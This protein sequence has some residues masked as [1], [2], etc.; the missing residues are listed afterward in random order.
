VGL[1]GILVRQR[2]I[3]AR[4][5]CRLRGGGRCCG[6]VGLLRAGV[7]GSANSVVGVVISSKWRDPLLCR[8]PRRAGGWVAGCE[9]VGAG[10]LVN[11]SHSAARSAAPAWPATGPHGVEVSAPLGRKFWPP[12][13]GPVTAGA[14]VTGKLG[15]IKRADGSVQATR[16]WDYLCNGRSLPPG[17]KQGCSVVLCRLS[18][19]PIG[20]PAR[21]CR[22]VVAVAQ[23][24]A[25]AGRASGG[26][27][28][29]ECHR[30]NELLS[31]GSSDEALIAGIAAGSVTAG[32]DFV[33]RH[34]SRVFGLALALVGDP[35]TAE[36]VAQDTFLRVWRHAGRF[37]AGKGSVPTWLS[38]ISR[39]L[40]IDRLRAQRTSPVDPL[41]LRA[42]PVAMDSDPIDHV[43]R[44]ED[45]EQVRT[46]VRGLP[47]PQQRAVVL[48]AFGQTAAEISRIE[49]IPLG[50][51]KTRI[52]SAIVKLRAA[53]SG[54][55]A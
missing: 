44:R 20:G 36:E 15:T 45:I 25:E 29:A 40:A 2:G 14:G 37:D 32:A 34:Q 54:A 6:H 19:E 28:L 43:T 30:S 7:A 26:G 5:A 53:L 35:G 16:R 9:L 51:A 27:E 17:S 3:L 41:E 47:V 39:N 46:A 23:S 24:V 1:V 11:P 52:R 21:G 55:G 8:V 22:E 49:Q 50:T 38:V 42:E 13:K 10:V 4:A 18:G 12:V 33:R 48:A 31:A